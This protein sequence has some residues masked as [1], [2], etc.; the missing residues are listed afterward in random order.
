MIK[1]LALGNSLSQDATRYLHDIAHAAGDDIKVVNLYIGGCTLA[2][3]YRNMLS[4]AK[5]YGY[6]FNGSYV[7]L[8]VSLDE[9]LYSDDWDYMTIQQA[10]YQSFSYE[11]CRPYIDRIKEHMTLA[12]PKAKILIHQIWGY[13][14]GSRRLKEAGYSDFKEMLSASRAVT[15]RLAGELGFDGIVPCGDAMALAFDGGIEKLHRDDI[16]VSYGLGR[17]LTGLVWYRTF[18]GKNI[19]GNTFSDLD[20]PA[21]ERD[22]AIAKRAAEQAV[23]SCRDINKLS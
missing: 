2:R 10:S 1:I 16:H 19:A 7:G 3:H 4:G 12:C 5:E 11:S 23:E 8:K 14:N 21:S 9:A 6:E 13:Q 15:H 20:E 17:Y 22:I 18:T